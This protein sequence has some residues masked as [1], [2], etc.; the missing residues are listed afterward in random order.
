LKAYDVTVIGAGAAGLIAAGRAAELG[1]NVLLVEKMERAGRKLLITGKGRC[2]ITNDT[3]ITEYFKQI[4]PNG[5]FLKHAFSTFFVNDIISLLNR[6][7]VETTVERGQRVFPSSNKASDIVNALLNWTISKKT[8]I[9]YNARVSKLLYKDSK[10]LGLE[11]NI[12]GT[13]NTI[14]SKNII[15]C[16]GGNSYPATGSTGDGYHLAME[17][18]HTIEPVRPALVPL[19][20]EGD[21]AK[22]LQGL[23]LKNVNAVVWINGK[24]HTEEFGEMLFTHFGLSGPIILTLSRIVVDGIRNKNKVEISVDLKPALDTQKLDAR[25]VRD[26]NEHGK[27]RIDNI[28]REWLP[29]KLIPVFLNKI[30][31]DPSLECN[32]VNSKIRK[33]ILFLMKD[34]RFTISGHRSFKEAVITAGGVHLSEIDSKT[35][36]SKKI[37]GLYFAGEVIDLDANTGGFNLQIAWSTAWLAANSCKTNE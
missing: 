31:I 7:N 16:T 29:S 34:L 8:E 20:T 15:I 2:N 37:K 4:N 5:K 28:F 1:L 6:N 10:L 14:L 23:S 18:G 17:A 35:M 21:M 32:Q 12:N 25:L 33:Q 24:K 13:S 27:K 11:V 19:E 22:Q 26:L 3:D 36:E 9:L 30:G